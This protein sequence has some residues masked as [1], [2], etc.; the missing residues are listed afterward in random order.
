MDAVRKI[1]VIGPECTGKSTLSMALATTLCAPCVP[2]CARAWLDAIGRPYAEADLHAIAHAQILEEDALLREAGEYLICDTDLYV[3]KVWSEVKYG[4]CH[5]KILEAIATRRYHF[6]L[7]T[8]IDLPW[9]DD[10]QREHPR[11][12]DRLWLYRQYHDIIVNSGV[13][14]ASV[15]GAG[16]ERLQSALGAIRSAGL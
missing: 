13:P 15:S 7:L 10:P 16:N 8:N 9:A 3:L 1:V 5:R 11:P 4:R 2:E 6:Y 14:W 12:A